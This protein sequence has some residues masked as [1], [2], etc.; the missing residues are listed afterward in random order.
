MLQF[1]LPYLNNDLSNWVIYKHRVATV[2]GAHGLARHLEGNARLPMQ[3]T[4]RDGKFYLVGSSTALTDDEY[5]KRMN[6]QDAYDMKEAQLREII[7]QTIPLSLYVHVKGKA[8]AHDTWKELCSIMEYPSSSKIATLETR[9]MN[10]R[11]PENGDVRETLAQLQLWHE[12]HAGMG[13]TLPEKAY[14]NYVRQACG[15]SYGEFFRSLTIRTI[16]TNT[17]LT[18]KS[19]IDAVRREAV[20]R[21]AEKE[22]RLEGAAVQVGL[23]HDGPNNQKH[24]AQKNKKP[25]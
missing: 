17:P 3:V 13:V 16:V 10:L 4:E 7:Y 22:F 25:K 21:D 12:E 20:D 8:T 11:T 18:S 2:I 23:N 5:D 1:Q 9:M 24:R 19:L 14:M 6:E 15:T